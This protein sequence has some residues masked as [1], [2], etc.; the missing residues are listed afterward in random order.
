[1]TIKTATGKVFETDMVATIPE[2]AFA[3]IRILGSDKETIQKVFGSQ[4][5]TAVLKYGNI[6]INGFTKLGYII[7]E[8]NALKVRLE[9]PNG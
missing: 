7:P 2:P 3:Y 5:E 8:G 1:M 9:K 4:A 6:L